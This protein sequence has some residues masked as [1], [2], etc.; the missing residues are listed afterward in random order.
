MSIVVKNAQ[1]R[2]VIYTKG[3]PELL[4]E[5]CAFERRDGKI[6]SLSPARREKLLR[7]SSDM[8]NRAL[9]LLALPIEISTT[10]HRNIENRIWFLRAWSE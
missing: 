1:R 7:Q 9:R 8:A 2:A 10:I 3:A 5:R 4:L 6:V